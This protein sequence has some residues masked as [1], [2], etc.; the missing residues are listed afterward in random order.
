MIY[1]DGEKGKEEM[2]GEKTVLISE[3]GYI[4]QKFRT[5]I[6]KSEMEDYIN[7]FEDCFTKNIFKPLKKKKGKI[8]HIEINAKDKADAIRQIKKLNLD[9]DIEKEIIESL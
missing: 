4:Y 8:K 5:C 7:I 3:F 2:Y 9:K 6:E 1:I